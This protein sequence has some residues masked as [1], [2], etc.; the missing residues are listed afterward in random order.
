MILTNISV[1]RIKKI[2]LAL[3][4][5]LRLFKIKFLDMPRQVVQEIFGHV[6]SL[7]KH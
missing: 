7:V 5:L 1:A 4:T 6:N 3:F 2:L